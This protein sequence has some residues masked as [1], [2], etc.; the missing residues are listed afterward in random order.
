[1]QKPV[2]YLDMDQV[3]VDFNSSSSIPLEEKHIWG[4]PAIYKTGF[5]SN[6]RPMP[7]AIQFVHN[8]LKDGHFDVQI[9]TQPVIENFDSYSEKAAWIGKYLPSLVGKINMTQNKLLFKGYMLVDD[10]PK[11]QDF[12]GKFFLFNPRDSLAEFKQLESFLLGQK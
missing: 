12:D 5:F 10:N 2:I 8:L 7:G 11:W 9:L 3:L 4:H 6:L 1:M